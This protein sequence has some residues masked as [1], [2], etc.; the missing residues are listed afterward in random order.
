MAF[1]GI[2]ELIHLDVLLSF[3][4]V[5]DRVS[6]VPHG[7]HIDSAPID[8]GPWGSGATNRVHLNGNS[9]N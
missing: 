7:I 5:F 1:D 2:L 3:L 4:T 6:N 9:N 8:L